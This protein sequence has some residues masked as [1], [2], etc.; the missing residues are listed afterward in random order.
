MI[1]TPKTFWKPAA[2]TRSHSVG[3]TTAETR[4]PVWWT[5]FTTSRL[6]TAKR[7]RSACF[8][9]IADRLG[10]AAALGLV[11]AQGIEDVLRVQ[12]AV[13]G[14]PLDHPVPGGEQQRL[15]E[16]AVPRPEGLASP[17]EAVQRDLI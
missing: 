7:P 17:L 10:L 4:R 13:Q 11:E 2:K 16:L 3:R 15:P 9:A 14:G 12:E 1:E 8:G 5:N 6:D